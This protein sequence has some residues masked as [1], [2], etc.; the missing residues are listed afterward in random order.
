MCGKLNNMI[1]KFLKEVIKMGNS[2]Y[3]LVLSDEVV[4]AVDAL[5]HGNGLSRSALKYQR[6][7]HRF[8]AFSSARLSAPKSCSGG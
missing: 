1:S 3:S 8:P 2:I 6:S 5:A 7:I 4:D